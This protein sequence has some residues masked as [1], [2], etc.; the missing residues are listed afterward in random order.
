MKSAWNQSE[1]IPR[2]GGGGG[3]SVKG[4]V[5]HDGHENKQKVFKEPQVSLDSVK[6]IQ[7]RFQ[8]IRKSELISIIA[9]KKIKLS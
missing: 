2:T 7:T 3:E 6:V 9:F 8:K 5:F 4:G 1:I